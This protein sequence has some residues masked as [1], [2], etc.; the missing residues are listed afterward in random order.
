MV[1]D[2]VIKVSVVKDLSA[3]GLCF[4][5][6]E[7]G[8]M[9]ICGVVCQ[10]VAPVL[11]RLA[12]DWVGPADFLDPV[13]SSVFLHFEND[14]L[15]GGLS[16]H[17][18]DASLVLVELVVTAAVEVILVGDLDHRADRSDALKLDPPVHFSVALCE[19][20][21]GALAFEPARQIED[22]RVKRVGRDNSG[23]L[24]PDKIL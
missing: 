6:K 24:A 13:D 11:A 19:F 8:H 7:R 4:D 5:L 21:Y 20:H 17:V 12:S 3:E 1:Q 10:T 2:S 9:P 15:V 23:I 22:R 14:G 18:L 16:G